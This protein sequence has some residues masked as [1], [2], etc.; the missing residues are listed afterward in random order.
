MDDT[1]SLLLLSLDRCLLMG[2]TL[3]FLL[4]LV[5]LVSLVSSMTG[6]ELTQIL[7]QEELW[8]FWFGH[9]SPFYSPASLRT[10]VR[11]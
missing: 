1:Y 4:G 3:P 6:K 11:V 9:F 10:A 8:L 2:D 7:S 5:Y